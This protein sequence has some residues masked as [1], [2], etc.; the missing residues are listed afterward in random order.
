MDSEFL[1]ELVSGRGTSRRLVE[2][3]W[4]G[5]RMPLHEFSLIKTLFAPLATSPAALGLRDDVA[6]LTPRAG[7]E[8]VLTT[9]AIIA[10][11]DFFPNDPPDSIARNF[12]GQHNALFGMSDSAIANLHLNN[13]DPDRGVTFLEYSQRVNG[14]RVFEGTVQVAVN[15]K[16]EVLSVRQGFIT[17]GQTSNK[18]LLSET[19]GIAAAFAHAGRTVMPSFTN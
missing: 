19:E 6:L 7:H 18:P 9:D 14:I 1:P 15:A 2:G 11:V 5:A 4:E 3:L 12:L 10:G 16:G 17:S 8:L 13:E